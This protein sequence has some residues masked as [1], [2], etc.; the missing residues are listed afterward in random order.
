MKKFFVIFVFVVVVFLGCSDIT[1]NGSTN[2]ASDD[3][4]T[5][6]GN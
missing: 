1:T 4:A 5:W 3:F 6:Q 2:P